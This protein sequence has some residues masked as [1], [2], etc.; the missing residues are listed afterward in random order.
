LDLTGRAGKAKPTCL[1]T[2]GSESTERSE[3]MVDQI[4]VSWN[5]VASWLRPIAA[6]PAAADAIA[7]A[8]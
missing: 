7:S 1:I 4:G 5:H 6:L 8:V 3:G 2:V